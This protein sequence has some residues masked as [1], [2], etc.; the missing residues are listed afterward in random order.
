MRALFVRKSSTKTAW[1]IAAVGVL[2]ALAAYVADLPIGSENSLSALL[3]PLEST[4]P[5]LSQSHVEPKQTTVTAMDSASNVVPSIGQSSAVSDEQKIQKFLDQ[6]AADW[7]SK[8]LDGYLSAYSEH[9]KPE[10]NKSRADWLSE[11]R[12]RIMSKSKIKVRISDLEILNGKGT[13]IRFTQMYEAD[14][15]KAVTV[16]YMTLAL[17]LNDVGQMQIVREHSK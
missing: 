12:S 7:G 2:L 15:I 10:A 5:N 11:R 1:I 4:H 9:F 17:A 8:N 3:N 16:K 14:Q 13:E 6:W